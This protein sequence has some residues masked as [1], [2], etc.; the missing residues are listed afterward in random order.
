MPAGQPT[1][2]VV[3]VELVWGPAVSER[4]TWTV[5]LGSVEQTTAC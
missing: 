3:K 1:V 4:A 2:V 5:R